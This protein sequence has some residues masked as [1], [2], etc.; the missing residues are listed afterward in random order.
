MRKATQRDPEEV[1]HAA[2]CLLAL[3]APPDP[4]P[5]QIAAAHLLAFGLD[6]LRITAKA[7]G[8]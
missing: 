3:L 5:E 6:D 7:W 4:T 2:K 8:G 1:R